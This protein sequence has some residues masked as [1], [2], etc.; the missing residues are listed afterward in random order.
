MRVREHKGRTALQEG[1]FQDKLV[2][3]RSDGLIQRVQRYA[4]ECLVSGFTESEARRRV[5]SID[6]PKLLPNSE[7]SW[8]S[9]FQAHTV[10]NLSSCSSSA[11]RPNAPRMDVN[12]PWVS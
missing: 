5:P 3:E 12:D 6:A 4:C 9:H 1:L 8:I 2:H 7:S 11:C 10:K